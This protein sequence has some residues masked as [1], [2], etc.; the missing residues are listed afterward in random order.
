MANTDVVILDCDGVLSGY[1]EG[2]CDLVME[3]AGVSLCAE[4]FSGNWDFSKELEDVL[5][6]K[7]VLDPNMV[8]ARIRKRMREPGFCL[9]LPVYPYAQQ[10]VECLQRVFDRVL[11]VTSPLTGSPTWMEERSQWLLQHAGVSRKDVIHCDD[12]QFVYGSLFI[13]DKP[14]NVR[15]WGSRWGRGSKRVTPA[16]LWGTPFNRKDTSD[17]RRIDGWEELQGIVENQLERLPAR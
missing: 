10:M 12:K 2:F 3:H 17:L 14:L 9:C 8:A 16:L 5:R 13:D 4:D 15:T 11:V 7:G 1:F 6:Q